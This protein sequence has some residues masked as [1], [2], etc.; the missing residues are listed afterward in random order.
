[1]ED[2]VHLCDCFRS[3]EQVQQ[4]ANR[5]PVDFRTRGGGRE[6]IIISVGCGNLS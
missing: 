6:V 3:L 4:G 2:P 1:M 5:G